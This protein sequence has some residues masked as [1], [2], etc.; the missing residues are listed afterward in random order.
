[1][2][3]TNPQIKNTNKN[4]MNTN[5]ILMN[6]QIKSTKKIGA[7]V[8]LSFVFLL[9]SMGL[10][11]QSTSTTAATLSKGNGDG[12]SVKLVDNKGTIKYL[13]T[14]NGITSITSTTAGSTT[15]TTW[16]L[17]G[18][19]TDN[20]YIDVEGNVFSL[21]GLQLVDTSSGNAADVASIDAT[22]QSGHDAGTTTVA[23]TGSGW[24]LVVR[25][26]ATGALRKLLAEDLISGIY[27]LHTQGTDATAAVAITVAGLPALDDAT[28]RAKLFVYRNGIKL[29][30]GTDFDATA[31]T[32][33]TVHSEVALL[34]GDVVEIQYIK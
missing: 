17:G 13:Q 14:N 27:E 22:D 12:V 7:L 6:T 15:T 29:R 32:V 10:H 34:A 4:R 30:E 18:A 2:N 28:T 21:D 26:E 9:G 11:A 3:L 31:N 25:D 33:T 24:T 1:M 5:T 23:A 20:T 8:M 16:Q 19:L